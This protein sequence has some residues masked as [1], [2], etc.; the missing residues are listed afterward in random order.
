MRWPAWSATLLSVGALSATCAWWAIQ[1]AAPRPLPAPS[2]PVAQA[3]GPTLGAATRLF[4]DARADAG[5]GAA[6]A[7]ENV[8]VIGILSGGARGSAILSVDGKPAK[9]YAVGDRLDATMSLLSVDA[10]RVVVGSPAR[11]IELTPPAHGDVAV[12]RSGPA[13]PANAAGAADRSDR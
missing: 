12:L 4:G 9:A 13:R 5:A 6:K 8:T 7:S 11:K 10:G 2:H 3:D 1:L